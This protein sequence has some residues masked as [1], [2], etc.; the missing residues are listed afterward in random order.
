[1]RFA[2]AAL[3]VLA[4][5]G[6]A[7]A[8]EA[9]YCLDTKARPPAAYRG[10]P[11]VKWRV[12]R[13]PESKLRST[14]G[15]T[16]PRT[17]HSCTYPADGYWAVIIAGNISAAEYTCRLA[18]EKAHMPPFFWGDPKIELSETMQFLARQKA[19]YLKR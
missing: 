2:V 12:F 3:C 15:Y 10:E 19:D 1:M 16:G 13:V 8:S 18:Y 14:C 5:T 4:L 17:V 9:T 6:S 7:V 11:T